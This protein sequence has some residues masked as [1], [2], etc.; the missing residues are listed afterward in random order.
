MRDLS[1]PVWAAGLVAVVAILAMLT[2]P[3]APRDRA[4]ALA[5]ELRCPVCQGESIAD[6]PSDTA[7]SMEARVRELVAEG[8]SDEEIRAY[9]VARYGRWI[10]LDPP[11]SGETV[12]LWVLPVAAAAVGVTVLARRRRG[13]VTPIDDDDRLLVERAIRE[14]RT[15]EDAP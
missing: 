14:L 9:Y 4:D 12:A 11:F 3:T 8:R 6:S 13:S 10:L 1:W 2:G 5:Q 7:R 15:T